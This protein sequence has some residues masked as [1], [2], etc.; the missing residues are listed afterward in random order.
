MKIVPNRSR[1][2]KAYRF[3]CPNEVLFR[4]LNIKSIY[5]TVARPYD[6]NCCC[7]MQY[8]LLAPVGVRDAGRKSSTSGNATSA[9]PATETF[10]R[11]K[12]NLLIDRSIG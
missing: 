8:L 5:M 1:A 9:K 6:N 7:F 10:A 2:L 4:S 3:R 11:R 12:G